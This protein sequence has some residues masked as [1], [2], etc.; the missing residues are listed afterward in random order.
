MILRAGAN[1]RSANTLPCYTYLC[2]KVVDL[3]H[4]GFSAQCL[5]NNWFVTIGQRDVTGYC[6]MT[7]KQE[8]VNYNK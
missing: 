7:F 2:E 4:T 8:Q 6:T 3:K 1:N 5:E